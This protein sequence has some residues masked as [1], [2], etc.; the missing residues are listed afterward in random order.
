MNAY[1]YRPA[2]LADPARNP[3]HP[4]GPS[5]HVVTREPMGSASPTQEP[6][7]EHVH[8]YRLGFGVQK[9]EIRSGSDIRFFTISKIL[10]KTKLKF[11]DISKTFHLL[12]ENLVT[13][14]SKQG[15][16]SGFS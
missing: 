3:R 11:K 4:P 5:G 10:D 2:R 13:R 16:F 1:T 6:R 7:D 8:T 14:I 9:A 12:I 15:E